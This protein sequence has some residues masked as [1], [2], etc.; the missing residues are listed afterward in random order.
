MLRYWIRNMTLKSKPTAMQTPVAA[1]ITAPAIKQAAVTPSFDLLADSA[2]IREAQ[3]VPSPKRPGA[4]APLPFSAP[5]LW[6]KVKAGD[7]PAPVKLSAR[8]TCWQVG[9]IRAWMNAQ[10]AQTYTPA[11]V[12][13]KRSK[14]AAAP[15]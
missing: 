1:L 3:L 11:V 4:P 9:A 13:P 2:F 14:T 7:F 5:T 6:R 12:A 8:V 10:A 15:V